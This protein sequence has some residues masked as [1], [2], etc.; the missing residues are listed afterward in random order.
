MALGG[1]ERTDELTFECQGKVYLEVVYTA[2]PLVRQ[3]ARISCHSGYWVSE[4]NTPYAS[5]DASIGRA[6]GF[7][8][9]GG[10]RRMQL[11]CGQPGSRGHGE[12]ARCSAAC[13]PGP[14][15]AG[16]KGLRAPRIESLTLSRGGLQRVVRRARRICCSTGSAEESKVGGSGRSA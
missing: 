13:C 4:R 15:E 14:A 3:K 6:L 10:G 5:T 7:C 12:S 11:S 1:E 16:H 9:R 8:S 2:P